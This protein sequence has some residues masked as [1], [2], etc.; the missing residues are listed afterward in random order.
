VGAPCRGALYDYIEYPELQVQKRHVA[1]VRWR[2][3]LDTDASG[4]GGRATCAGALYPAADAADRLDADVD[5]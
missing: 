4:L 2:A 5:R 1:N 3:N